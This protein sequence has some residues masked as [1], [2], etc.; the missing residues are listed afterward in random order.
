MVA[1]AERLG[2]RSGLD[3]LRGIAVVLVVVSHT[4]EGIPW[5]DATGSVGVL[6]FFVLSGFLITRLMLEEQFDT[7][8]IRMGSFYVRRARRLLPALGV[9][10]VFASLVNVRFGDWV[11]TPVVSALTYSTNYAS[12][13]HD[14]E[15]GAFSHLW[16]LSVEEHFYFVWPLVVVAFGRRRLAAVC[17]LGIAVV[18]VARY[19]FRDSGMAYRGTQFRVDAMLV[20]A[21][22]AVSLRRF[23]RPPRWLVAISWITVA[24]FCHGATVA[25]AMAWGYGPLAVAA[26]A[27]TLDALHWVEVPALRHV[28]ELS[29][30]IYLYHL[31]LQL[32]LRSNGL[33][34]GW[35]LLAT[36]AV[37]FVAAEASYRWLEAPMRQP[38]SGS[39]RRSLELDPEHP[40]ITGGSAGII[41]TQPA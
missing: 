26:A 12:I 10:L 14:A 41:G 8:R 6:I 29:Y 16:S 39:S 35:L 25:A 5:L 31:P 1:N 18:V 4:T 24:V 33:I 28:G 11:L 21:W 40:S 23:G 19:V 22:M 27:L 2:H 37:S 13:G 17:V 36:L 20:G 9:T 30:G 7:G 38:R 32:L 3:Q 15:F 34:G